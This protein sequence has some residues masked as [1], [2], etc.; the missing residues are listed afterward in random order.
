MN[1]S[2]FLLRASV[3]TVILNLWLQ[4]D[5]RFRKSYEFCFLDSR[6]PELN[7]EWKSTLFGPK[8]LLTEVFHFVNEKRKQ[9]FEKAPQADLPSTPEVDFAKVFD[10]ILM[11]SGDGFD[12]PKIPELPFIGICNRVNCGDIYKAVDQF[13][14]SDLFS[15]FQVT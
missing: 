10:A 9:G 3:L 4:V 13:K 1:L 14:K 2:P 8:G 7:N 11:K 12:D 15:N 5:F 6:I